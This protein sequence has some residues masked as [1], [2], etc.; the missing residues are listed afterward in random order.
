MDPDE[1]RTPARS[2][3]AGGQ[4]QGEAQLLQPLVAVPGEAPWADT[5]V[6]KTLWP[7]QAGT[8]ALRKR[9]GGE[10]VCVRYRQ[11]PQSK[12]RYTTVE[13]LVDH[14]PVRYHPSGAARYLLSAPFWDQ[15][16]RNQLLAHGAKWN[17]EEQAW[18]MTKATASKLGVMR[19]TR[20]LK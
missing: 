1:V 17:H 10:L 3:T 5:R 15:D 13:L 20:R 2:Q 11:D 8:K 4:W 12:H 7:P 19:K 14:A 9:F 16:L 6:V 18:Q